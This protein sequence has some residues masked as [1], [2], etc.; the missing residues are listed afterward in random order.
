M[1]EFEQTNNT[2][3]IETD[4]KAA[5]NTDFSLNNG[6]EETE[7]TENVEK[8][9]NIKYIPVPVFVPMPEITAEE[10][11]KKEI[12]KTAML[13]GLACL[14]MMGITFF[15]STGYFALMGAFGFSIS[16]SQKIARD[17]FVLQFLQ[18]VLSSLMFTLPFI[19]IYK[20]GGFKISRTIELSKP[21]KQ[22]ILPFTLMGIGFCSFANICVSML[23][24]FFMGF[25][26]DYD[27]DRP[28]NPEGILGFIIS[29]IATAI[30]PALVEEF[31]FRGLILG[32]LKKYGEAFAIIVSS[33]VFGLLHGNFEQI[34]F[35]FLVGLIL[36]FVTVKSGSIWLACLIHFLNNGIS[37]VLDFV[38]GS[39]ADEYINLFYNVYLMLALLLGIIGAILFAKC[40]NDAFNFKKTETKADEITKHRWFFTGPLIIILV[41]VCFVEAMQYFF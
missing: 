24:S 39:V 5:E 20:M 8:E 19:L 1:Q 10:K 9:E 37:I 41:L 31:A 25:G 33:V 17:P 30:V 11:E 22:K 26:V 16:E 28:D 6:Q 21:E 32:S 2:E 12:K 29:F 7:N 40:D 38:L 27:L 4:N 14:V 36:G 34:P 15:W 23:G 3:N 35:A 18:I 13:A